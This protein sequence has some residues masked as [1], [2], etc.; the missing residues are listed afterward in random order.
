M[1]TPEFIPLRGPMLNNTTATV[2]VLGYVR[3]GWPVFPVHT[4]NGFG[5]SCGKADCDSPGKHPRTDNGFKDATTDEEQVR[6]WDAKWPGCN[7]GVRTGKESGLFGLDI[8][9]G[10]EQTLAAWQ[11]EHGSA[12]LGTLQAKTP[13]GGEHLIFG[14][15]D[16]APGLK[17]K[18]SNNELG[19]GVD[20]RGD[21]GYLVIP[22]SRRQA[23]N[24]DWSND[25]PIR[26]A[27]DWLLAKVVQPISAPKVTENRKNGTEPSTS[28]G[29]PDG[30]RN[31]TLTSLAGSMR[32][33]GMSPEAIESGLQTEN[34]VRC[35][36]PLSRAE[37]SKIGASVARYPAEGDD[38]WPDVVPINY[39]PVE[40]FDPHILPESLRP[41]TS[42]VSERM[43]TPPDFAAAATL[44]TLAGS[45]NRRALVRPKQSDFSWEIPSNL[46]GGLVGAPGLLKTP[47]LA[48]ITKPLA[49][50]E[51]AWRE[52]NKQAQT[53]FELRQAQMKIEQEI[54]SRKYKQACESGDPAFDNHRPEPEA[55]PAQKRLII[56]DATSE[57]LQELMIQNPPGLFLVR[58]EL[59]G[60]IATLD[61]AGRE[62]DRAFYL[63]SWS[64]NESFSVDRIGRGSLYIPHVCLSLFGNVQPSRLQNYMSDTIAGVSGPN[65]DGMFQR[66]Q[67]LVYPDVSPDWR[68]VDRLPDANAIAT[69]QRI[70]SRLAELP[71]DPPLRLHFS[72]PAQLFFN[73][74]L[75]DLEREIRSP[76]DLAPA[77]V[78]HLAK[79]RSLLPKLAGLYELCDRVAAGICLTAGQ[80]LEISLEHASQAGATCKYLRSHAR[81]I[82]GG[83]VSAEMVT[84]QDLSAKL[85]QGKLPSTFTT[86]NLYRKCWAGMNTPERARR[87]LELLASFGWVRSIASAEEKDGRPTE[88]WAVNPKVVAQ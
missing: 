67:I 13:R 74:W 5:C 4:E 50:I 39:T 85:Q 60:F 52:E 30:E 72:T 87:V 33:R 29:I 80:A 8:D 66:F 18:T 62:A 69:A 3:H 73:A 54:W 14:Y 38:P 42:D 35:D 70:F 51:S 86:R 88:F 40:P 75:G 22:P 77:L 17:V 47:L 79:Y 37:V 21:G 34:S 27:P 76:G 10:G 84:A 9:P 48:A 24:Y 36:P 41:L 83:I 64:G 59:C 68:L 58:D 12:W 49:V 6:R 28:A 81:R 7:W 78:A 43:Q 65:N 23:G 61:K 46:W 44:V 2:P 57:K 56:T 63:Q 55:P 1:S 82:Y 53:R 32:R 15:P 16:L 20:I 11:K 19:S 71:C 31:S 25:L 45:V 26:P